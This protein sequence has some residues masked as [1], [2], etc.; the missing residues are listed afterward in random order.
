MNASTSPNF[1]FETKKG[2]ISAC[3]VTRNA[4]ASLQ[5][6][7]DSL[8]K[9]VG[10]VAE[11]DIIVVDN[12]ST[13]STQAMLKEDFPRAQHIFC[14]PGIGFS[15]G[16]NTALAASRGEF[17]L[18]AT[19]STEITGDAIPMLLNYLRKFDDVGVVGPKVLNQNGSTQHSSKK[20]PNPKVAMLHT[21]YLFG[22]I[23]PRK[24][25]NEYF[26]YDYKSDEPLKV[27][28]LTMSLMLARRKVFEDVGLLDE[29]LFAWSS[30]VDWCY[31]V[32]NSQWKQIFIPMARV[33][34][35]RSSVSNKQPFTNLMHYHRDLK[36]FYNKHFAK[37]NGL[38]INFLWSLM[39]QARFVMQIARYILKRDRDYSFY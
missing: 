17:I 31:R 1:L 23:P 35:R 27:D 16:I 25:L 3:I 33:V 11:L 13:D 28:S 19:P 10:E 20:M 12:D 29:E 22:I 8:I 9:S 5:G 24:L 2:T 26:L 6:Y 36:Y 39:L 18:I 34:H 7:L 14:K 4:C 32:E 15:K 37:K 21:L 38:F 30:D